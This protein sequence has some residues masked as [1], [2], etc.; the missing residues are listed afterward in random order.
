MFKEIKKLLYPIEQF[1][2][3]MMLSLAFFKLGFKKFKFI[4]LHITS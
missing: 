1:F 4:N 3:C 2:L